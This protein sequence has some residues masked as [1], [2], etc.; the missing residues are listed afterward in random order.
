M[1]TFQGYPYFLITLMK[2]KNNLSILCNSNFLKRKKN[3]EKKNVHFRVDIGFL[4]K[5]NV[6]IK[7]KNG[8]EM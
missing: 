6:S 1:E 8:I 7:V 4:E 3:K 2:N 5:I